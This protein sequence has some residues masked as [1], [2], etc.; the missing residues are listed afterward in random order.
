MSRLSTSSPSKTCS[1]AVQTRAVQICFTLL[2]LVAAASM[3]ELLPS[4]GGAKAPMLVVYAMYAA[5]R[6]AHGWVPV[7]AA[8]G[9]FEDALNGIPSLCCTCF[10]LL[11]AT[12]AYFA[13]PL[14]RG[15]PPAGAGA[16]A[17]MVA[18]PVH[19]LWLSSWG[20]LPPGCPL[21][22]R[23]CASALPAAA[24]GAL[25]FAFLPAAEAFAGF[26]GPPPERRA[27]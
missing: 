3:Q 11:A 15:M 1:F 26:G 10:A 14:T 25:A 6:P 18:A 9:A 8:C 5:S 24:A 12:A 7:A 27:R 19:E 13:R 21:L 4:F 22:V 23:F 20:V 16:V 17:A 2:C